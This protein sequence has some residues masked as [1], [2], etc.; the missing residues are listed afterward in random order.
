MKVKAIQRKI[1][2]KAENKEKKKCMHRLGIE[3]KNFGL[4][5][6]ASLPVGLSRH[7]AA[8]IEL[9]DLKSVRFRLY[10]HFIALKH[11]V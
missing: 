4:E 6:I 7:M 8:T 3:P 2:E 9:L 10:Q 1:I 11:Q 5:P